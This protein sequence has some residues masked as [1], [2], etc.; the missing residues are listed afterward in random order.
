MLNQCVT[1][2]G[3]PWRL[4]YSALRDQ[5]WT[6]YS[7]C[8]SWFSLP[9]TK[10]REWCSRILCS[11]REPTQERWVDYSLTGPGRAY[12]GKPRVVGAYGQSRDRMKSCTN[13]FWTRAGPCRRWYGPTSNFDCNVSWGMF[14]SIGETAPGHGDVDSDGF[15]SWEEAGYGSLGSEYSRRDSGARHGID[16]L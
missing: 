6:C 1:G 7:H 14:S 9:N 8:S 5:S 10:G 4:D 3:A 13:L 11:V 12:R 15:W 16:R 2:G